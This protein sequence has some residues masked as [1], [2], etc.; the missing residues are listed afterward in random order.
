M[1]N[2][3]LMTVW[4][5]MWNEDPALAHDL[6]TDECVQWSGNTTGLDA[7]VGPRE[8]EEFVTAYRAEHVNVFTPRVLVDGGDRFAYLWDVRTADGR[9]LTGVD[10]NVVRDGRVHENWTFVGERHDGQAD[11]E[12]EAADR[13]V[14]EDL[15]LGWTG[16]GPVADRFRGT[17]ADDLDLAVTAHREVVVDPDRGRVALLRTTGEDAVSGVDLFAV[18]EG[19]VARAWSLTGVRPFRY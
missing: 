14:L 2:E 5:R 16:D 6:M 7:V 12:P 11:P 4:C 18:R 1:D 15:A 17:A 8:Q 9:V 10:V 3:K 19:R 13:A